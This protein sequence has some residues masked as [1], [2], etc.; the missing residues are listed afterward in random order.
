MLEAEFR[1]IWNLG[2]SGRWGC[3]SPCSG[4]V[5]GGL[6]GQGDP[7]RDFGELLYP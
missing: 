5:L 2:V 7:E 1:E 6:G 4:K 3:P